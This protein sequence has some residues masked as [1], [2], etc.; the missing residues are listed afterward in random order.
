MTASCQVGAVAFR[1]H[2]VGGTVR[3]MDI[4]VREIPAGRAAAAEHIGP[5]QELGRTFAIVGTWAAAH[6]GVLIGPPRVL[7]ADDPENTPPEELHSYVAIPVSPEA[8]F[9]E[10]GEVH[11]LALPGGRYAVAVHVGPYDELATAWA[12]FMAG[13]GSRE[14]APDG[15]RSCFEVYVSDPDTT[16]ANEL[17]TE[18]YQPIG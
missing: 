7:Y 1:W 11:E 3:G 16:S 13:V 2:P 6:S 8:S 14:L 17:I 5:F 4:E 9:E 10:S 18:L 15:S 12:Q